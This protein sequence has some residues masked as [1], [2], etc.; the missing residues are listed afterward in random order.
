MPLIENWKIK[1]K[2][3]IRSKKNSTFIF[4]EG[5]DNKVEVNT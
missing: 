1:Y 5:I 2:T 4:K 3:S